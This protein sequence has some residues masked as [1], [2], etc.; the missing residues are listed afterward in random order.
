MEQEKVLILNNLGTVYP[1]LY[2]LFNQNFT[3]IGNKS[4]ARIAMGYRAN[5]YSFVNENDCNRK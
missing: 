2:D 4:Y 3:I 1:G 5:A